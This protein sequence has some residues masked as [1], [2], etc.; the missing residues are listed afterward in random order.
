MSLNPVYIYIYIYIY[1][2]RERER[3]NIRIN[4]LLMIEVQGPSPFGGQEQIL[5]AKLII[6]GNKKLTLLKMHFLKDKI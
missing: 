6:K 5:G 4:Q 2:E 3:E 1:R